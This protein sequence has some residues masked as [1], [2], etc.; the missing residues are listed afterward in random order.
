M[1]TINPPNITISEDESEVFVCVS[2][3]NDVGLARD[4]VVTAQTGA[5]TGA[6]DQ[7]TGIS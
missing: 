5:K 1:F 6:D 2:K 4:I 3:I 7:A